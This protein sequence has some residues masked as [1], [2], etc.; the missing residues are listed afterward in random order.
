MLLD[1]MPGVYR[2]YSHGHHEPAA[3]DGYSNYVAVTENGS[4]FNS[5]P[6]EVAGSKGTS[7][8]LLVTEVNKSSVPWLSPTDISIDA[9]QLLF[10]KL[11]APLA[12][13]PNH[14]SA[15]FVVGFSD[16][17]GRLIPLESNIALGAQ[18]PDS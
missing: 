9:F 14:E 16:C 2:C 8:S 4:S 10:G 12:D 5:K 1:R 17:S 11:N 6:L 3:G 15:G 7:N 18:T 13:T